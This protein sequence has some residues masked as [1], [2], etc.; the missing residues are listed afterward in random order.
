MTSRY[1]YKKITWIDL[2]SPTQEEVRALMQEF[3]IHPLVANELLSPT[4]RPK[5]DLYDNLIYLILHFPAFQHSHGQRPEQEV[6]FLIGKDFIITTHYTMIDTLHE[7]SKVFEVKSI[8]DKSH[9]SSHAGFV[10]FYIAK[11][12]YRSLALELD[13]IN[14][15]M[16]EAEEN[17]FKGR[18]RDM[19]GEISRINKNLLGFKQSIRLHKEVLSSLEVA[20][21]RFF[22]EKFS[23]YLS[24]ISGEYYKIASHL[25]GNRETILELRN[26]NDSLLSTK[27]N[28]VMKILTIMAFVTFPLS[29]IAAIFG[30]NTAH[31]PIVGTPGD[32]WI[33]MGIMGFATF[34][35]FLYFKRK[36][37]I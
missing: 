19:V 15:A 6:D 22:G 10:F 7:F 11:E 28:E 25:E 29:L 27:Q 1:K 21:T 13:Y 35:M 23:Y 20:G 9:I 5:V 18:E 30:M 31:I 24:A 16:Q 34:L 4:V 37:W 32:F 26:T 36:K 2:E 14:I 8:I 17:I 3:D 33:V 12:L